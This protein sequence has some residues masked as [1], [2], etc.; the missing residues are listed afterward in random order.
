MNE[1]AVELR[2]FPYPFRAMLAI[3]SDIDRTSPL[4][5]RE[6]HRFL[7]TKEDTATGPGL[8]LDIADSMWFYRPRLR[9]PDPVSSELSYFDGD[10]WNAVTPYADELLHY[11]RC[12]WIDTIHGYGNFDHRKDPAGRWG[13]FTRR[14]AE[15]ALSVLR[16]EGLTIPVWSNHGNWEN[17]QNIGRAAHMRG[18]DPESPSYHADL[19]RD[20]G[21][22][23]QWGQGAATVTGAPTKL[24]VYRLKDGADCWQFTRFSSRPFEEAVRDGLPAWQAEQEKTRRPAPMLWLPRW[25][26]VQLAE[27]VLERL[28][29]QQHLAIVAQHLGTARPMNVLGGPALERLRRLAELQEQGQILVARTARLLA[30]NRARDHLRYTMSSRDGSLTIDVVRIED[31]V[32]G[33]FTPALHDVRGIT[34]QVADPEHVELRLAGRQVDSAQIARNPSDG[35]S[36][37]IGFRW[38]EPDLRDH[39]EPFARRLRVSAP[40]S[41]RKELGR[42][43]GAILTAVTSEADPSDVPPGASAAA[44]R[45]A[46]RVF[47]QPLA[48][49]VVKLRALGFMGLE[50]LHLGS[51]V[52]EWCVAL[53]KAGAIKVVGADPRPAFV[54]VART[55]AR[56]AALTDQLEF[57]VADERTASLP[58]D[59]FE[60]VLWRSAPGFAGVEAVIDAAA[61]GLR[62]NGA[63]Y[64]SYTGIGGSLRALERMLQT[65]DRNWSAPTRRLLA[66]R[67]YRRGIGTGLNDGT[68]PAFNDLLAVAHSRG[69]A[70]VDRPRIV[71]GPLSFNELPV[72]VEALFRRERDSGWCRDELL[73]SP[74][75]APAFLARLTALC[76]RGAPRLVAEV[77]SRRLEEVRDND[78][79]RGLL[80]RALVKAGR[81]GES[82]VDELSGSETDPLTTGLI[83]HARGALGDAID[84]Y[85]RVSPRPRFLIGAVHLQSGD[86]AAAWESFAKPSAG[87]GDRLDCA[88]GLLEVAAQRDDRQAGRRSFERLVRVLAGN[89]H[90]PDELS[91]DRP[92]SGRQ[93]NRTGTARRHRH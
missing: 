77:L 37:S 40:S 51:G 67:L 88:L 13:P 15:V 31:P 8:G 93:R 54:A 44:R 7:N 28:I 47:A 34:F 5:F 45:T 18:D 4:R 60:F 68:S 74:I 29:E 43:G 25:L 69:L 83:H 46:G 39:S 21:V 92:S 20:A 17:T 12:G 66:D 71:D 24:R 3:N 14:H 72:T 10:D 84:G 65:D 26:H 59:R 16:G 76:D 1:Q 63:L 22:I 32:L 62:R 42:V 49:L 78:P 9:E 6:L 57:I 73:D 81:A 56:A 2:G 11:V 87:A 75:G 91:A 35:Q 41:E 36:P 86:L 48:D 90:E 50:T 70:F 82:L 38:F 53:A 55:A 23:F 33:S 79:L 19:L 61:S 30:Y 58:S 85:A 80:V 64:A 52:G 27:P 89:D